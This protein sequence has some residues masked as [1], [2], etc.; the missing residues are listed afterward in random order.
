MGKLS[1]KRVYLSGPMTG[2]PDLGRRAFNEAHR[3]CLRAGATHVFNPASKWAAGRGHGWYMRHDLHEL[4]R[5]TRPDG[6]P[7]YDV[8]VSLPG[9]D[10]SDGAYLER[11]VAE[12]CEIECMGLREATGNG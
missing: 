10:M 1:G 12:E 6:K 2:R 4:M 3:L 11:L 9:W 8:L 7:Y 5:S